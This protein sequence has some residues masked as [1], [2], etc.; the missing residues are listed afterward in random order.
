MESW[1]IIQ[2][3]LFAL[4]CIMSFLF[5]IP[6]FFI[7]MLYLTFI[8]VFICW[9][10]L[11]THEYD[12]YTCGNIFYSH[13]CDMYMCLQAQSVYPCVW[14]VTRYSL[15]IPICNFFPNRSEFLICKNKF[16]PQ[17]GFLTAWQIFTVHV[18]FFNTV[19]NVCPCS[20]WKMAKYIWP[21]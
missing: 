9:H 15:E 10:A 21:M 1:F 16:W 11:Y 5:I 8:A 4:N 20:N 13:W 12:L 14:L 7:C 19:I 6:D 17:L 2:F 3:F 18:P